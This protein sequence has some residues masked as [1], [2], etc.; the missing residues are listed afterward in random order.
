M[1]DIL[2]LL[3][4]SACFTTSGSLNRGGYKG[5]ED[6]LELKK[7]TEETERKLVEMM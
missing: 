7:M 6:E 4:T 2:E 5:S 3:V 1:A